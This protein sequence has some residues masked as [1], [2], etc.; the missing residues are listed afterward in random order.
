MGNKNKAMVFLALCFAGIMVVPFIASCGKNGG[1]SPQ[2]SRIT[3]QVVNL[4]PDLQSINLWI[5]FVK[6][7]PYPFSYPN[8]S[9]YFSLTSIDTP[10]Q[11][12][13]ASQLVSTTNL[14]SRKDIVLKP[15]LRYT[16]FV[17]GLR[18]DSSAAG[19]ITSIFTVDTAA[20]PNPGRGKIRFVNASPRST[21]FDIAANDAIA[22]KNV[23][24]KDVT[25][26]IEIPP[27]TYEFK[28]MPTGLTTVISSLKNVSI[29]EGKVY[30]LYCRGVAGGADS[31]AF[32]AGIIS[33]R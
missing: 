22:F 7:N 23:V 14:I 17:T 20:N 27:G 33:N 9:G 25:P 11:I 18:A 13:S 5:G 21:S 10:I 8:P 1:V 19:R 2:G 26:F 16:L 30:T 4:G 3:M 12:R 6:Q 28:I 31:V 24:Y 29:V 15:N 32:G